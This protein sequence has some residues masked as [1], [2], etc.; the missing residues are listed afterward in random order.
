MNAESVRSNEDRYRLVD[1]LDELYGADALTKNEWLRA[2]RRLTDHPTPLPPRV[3]P[4]DSSE[5]R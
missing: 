5:E 3:A 1:L 2:R 4:I